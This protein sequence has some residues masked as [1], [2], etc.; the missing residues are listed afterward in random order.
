[1][2]SLYLS[3]DHVTSAFSLLLTTSAPAAAYNI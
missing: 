3:L 2:S 1:V